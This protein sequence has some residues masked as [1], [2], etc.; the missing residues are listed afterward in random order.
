MAAIEIVEQKPTPAEYNRLFEAV[1]WPVR[2]PAAVEAALERSLFSV[3]AVTD[4]EVIGMG[5][6]VGD[7]ALVNYIQDVIVLPEH[8]KQ[9]I[10]E[11]IMLAIMAYLN[12]HVP[13]GS[14]LALITRRET[15]GFYER[16]GFAESLHEIPSM[17]RVL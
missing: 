15:T 1:G 3:C 14:V 12:E 4:G 5:R 13:S 7:G 11:K 2:D 8:Q 6:I 10:G 9:G 16:H 17:R